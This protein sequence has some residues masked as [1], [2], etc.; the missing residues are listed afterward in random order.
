LLVALKRPD[1]FVDFAERGLFAYDWSDV[2]RARRDEISAY[3]LIAVPT[4]PINVAQL[5]EDVATF[6]ADVTL[7]GVIF[8]TGVN[9]DVEQS[10]G[11]VKGG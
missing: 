9:L 7:R 11:C 1:D 6:A 5:P 2:H 3:E 10:I 4:S 8:G